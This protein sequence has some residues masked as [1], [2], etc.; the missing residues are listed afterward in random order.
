MLDTKPLF[1]IKKYRSIL[2]AAAIVE[3]VSY[4]VSLTDSIVAGNMINSSAFAAIGLISPFISVSVFV[5]SII[6]SGTIKYYSDYIGAFENR[7]AKEI[8]SQGVYMS[9]LAGFAYAAIMFVLRD[10]IIS[11]LT[12]SAVMQQYAREYYNIILLMIVIHPVSFLIDNMTIADGGEKLSAVA[13]MIFIISNIVLS[14]VFARLWGIKGIA[15]AS[16]V[17]RYLFVLNHIFTFSRKKE[18]TKTYMALATR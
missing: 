18:Y 17:S 3:A 7:R 12:D 4:I 6:N 11:I 14:V 5:S 16:A 8:F 13:N 15:A 2:L 10:S 1:V 9:I